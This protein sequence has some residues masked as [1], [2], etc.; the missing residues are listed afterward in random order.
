MVVPSIIS[1]CFAPS[2]CLSFGRVGCVW[3]SIENETRMPP[4]HTKEN[5]K[6]AFRAKSGDHKRMAS[7]P[8]TGHARMH[9]REKKK[10]TRSQVSGLSSFLVELVR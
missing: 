1:S 7:S 9:D 6:A 2:L 3:S 8:F 5:C 4:Q 10:R